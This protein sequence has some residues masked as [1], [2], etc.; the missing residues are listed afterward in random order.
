MDDVGDT[1]KRVVY[2]LL[3]SRHININT[4]E[5]FAAETSKG[6]PSIKSLYLSQE[7]EITEPS[8]A[9]NASAIKETL[10]VHHIKRDYI[11]GKCLFF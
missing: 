1:I 5:E 2:G 11:F 4:A 8:F 9:I 10:D 7:D 6:V 3:K